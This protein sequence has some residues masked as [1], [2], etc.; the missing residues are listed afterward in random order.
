MPSIF[1]MPKPLLIFLLTVMIV[2]NSSVHH[3][4]ACSLGGLVLAHHNELCD[5]WIEF[6][7]CTFTP[8]VVHDKLLI[9]PSHDHLVEPPASPVPSASFSQPLA[10]SSDDQGNLLIFGLWSCKTHC[11]LDIHIINMDTKSIHPKTPL[12]YWP[13]MRKSIRRNILLLVSS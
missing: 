11:I 7:S 4:L 10:T 13:P 12:R 9:H 8:R 3:G 1:A 5:E 2:V 6:A